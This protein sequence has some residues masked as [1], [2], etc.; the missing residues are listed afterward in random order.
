LGLAFEGKK[1]KKKSLRRASAPRTGGGKRKERVV[2]G[3]LDSLSRIKP[4]K[5]RRERNPMAWR[6]RKQKGRER[7]V[8]R[9]KKIS[10]LPI[11][12]WAGWELRKEKKEKQRRN[13]SAANRCFGDKQKKTGREQRDRQSTASAIW[14]GGKKKGRKRR[15]AHPSS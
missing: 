2:K 4:P 3:K 11:P 14:A 13:E 5:K 1:K 9:D 10:C 7:K 12:H 6:H 8:M 15:R